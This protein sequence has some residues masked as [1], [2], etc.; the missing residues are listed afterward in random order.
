[1][2]VVDRAA[3]SLARGSGNGKS[4]CRR[5]R[6]IIDVSISAMAP[7]LFDAKRRT[8]DDNRCRLPS[9]ITSHADA[10]ASVAFGFARR[11]MIKMVIAGH[12]KRAGRM[13]GARTQVMSAR[14]GG[15]TV[16]SLC[17]A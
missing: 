2:I 1:M 15:A 14:S 12:S 13:I 4:W 17:L 3:R 5:N 11:G 7:G 16:S 9:V 6:S 8:I 10:S